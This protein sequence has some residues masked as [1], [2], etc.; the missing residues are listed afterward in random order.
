MTAV[1]V[2]LGFLF[3]L[4]VITIALGRAPEGHQDETGF[5]HRYKDDQKIPREPRPDLEGGYVTEGDPSP[6]H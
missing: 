1:A 2:I 5:H 4:G 6:T 3:A